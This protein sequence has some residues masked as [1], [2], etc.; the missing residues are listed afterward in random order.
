[1]QHNRVTSELTGKEIS[2]G[3]G[4]FETGGFYYENASFFDLLISE[5]K[6]QKIETAVQSV[7]VAERIRKRLPEYKK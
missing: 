7:E 4:T 1:M 3:D 5:Q 2:D 6:P